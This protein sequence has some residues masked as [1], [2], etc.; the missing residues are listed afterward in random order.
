LERGEI[1]VDVVQHRDPRVHQALRRVARHSE[2]TSTSAI[3]SGRSHQAS[4]PP[5]VKREATPRANAIP[6]A[7]RQSSPTMKF[8]QKRPNERTYLTL[9]HLPEGR[10]GAGGAAPERARTTGRRGIRSLR[11]VRARCRA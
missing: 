8:H 5:W 9:A 7:A 2:S 3:A 10:R 4:I 1:A 6:A 11:A